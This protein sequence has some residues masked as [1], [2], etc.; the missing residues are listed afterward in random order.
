MLPFLRAAAP[1]AAETTTS[2]SRR[3]D[4]SLNGHA[5]PAVGGSHAS[6]R[7]ASPLASTA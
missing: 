2:A 4:P 7:S 3:S 1:A 6:G 5:V